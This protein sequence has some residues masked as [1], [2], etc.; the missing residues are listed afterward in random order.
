MHDAANE[1]EHADKDRQHEVI[2][3]SIVAKANYA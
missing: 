3:D 2:H 1:N